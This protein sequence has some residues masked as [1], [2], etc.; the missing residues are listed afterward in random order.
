MAK[1]LC[2]LDY[3]ARTGFGT[4]SK[5]IVGE[6]R[7][8]YGDK[9]QLDIIAINY[10]GEP[11]FE[12]KNTCVISAVK[13]DV[14]KDAF[15]RYFFLKMLKE[16]DYDGIFICQDIGVIVSFMEVLEHI[17]Q[18]K[19]ENNQTDLENTVWRLVMCQ[20]PF[21]MPICMSANVGACGLTHLQLRR[22]RK[23]N[24]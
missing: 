11:F 10:F 3:V 2:L 4:V 12:D 8:H 23:N 14:K 13:N 1:V 9:L 5:N 24:V 21:K 15:G 20:N 7:K 18:E 22:L 17:R 6:L 19:K 16:G